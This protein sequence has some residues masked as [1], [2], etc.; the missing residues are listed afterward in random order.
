MSCENLDAFVFHRIIASCSERNNRICEAD[1]IL[2]VY[3]KIHVVLLMK[4]MELWTIYNSCLCAFSRSR[5]A[6]DIG[7]LQTLTIL[8][9]FFIN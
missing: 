9:I 7:L 2:H 6:R 8:C 5:I 4:Y 1:Q 3:E